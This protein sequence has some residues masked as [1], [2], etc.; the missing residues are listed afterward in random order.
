MGNARRWRVVLGEHNTLRNEGTEQT[1]EVASILRHGSYSSSTIENDIAIM[2]LKETVTFN[3]YI[4]PVCVTEGDVSAGTSCVTTGWGETEGI[5][6][7]TFFPI[8]GRY[9]LLLSDLFMRFP[10]SAW[11]VCKSVFCLG[12]YWNERVSFWL[13]WSLSIEGRL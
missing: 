10:F 6:P 4:S 3:D 8:S 2:E 13:S 7:I 9:V 12:L 5:S 11:N 1:F